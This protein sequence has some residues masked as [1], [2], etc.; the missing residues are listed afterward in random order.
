MNKVI[1][2]FLFLLCALPL[3]AQTHQHGV[4]T[5]GDGQFNPFVTADARG[6]F[7]L[8]YIER[9]NNA[10]NV[11]L[12]HA[13]DGVNFSAPVRVNDQVGDATVRNENPPKVI[14]GPQGDVYVCWA[15]ER[16]KWKG[17]IRFARST[18]GG[19]TFAPALTINSDGT[20]EPAGHAFQSLAVDKQGRIYIAWIDERNKQKE[21]RGAEIWLTISTDR[22]KTF[23]ADRRILTDVCECCRTNLQTDASGNLYLSY[24]TV[25]RDGPMFRD[26]IVARSSD[27]GKTFVPTVVSLD[28]W[29][30]NG[31][32]VAGPSL[33]VSAN[34][35]I[36]VAWFMGGIEK[37]GLYYAMSHDSGT[38]FTTRQW[39][40]A[41]KRMGKHVHSALT[42]NGQFWLAW[43]D[44][45]EQPFS[46]WGV[47][48]RP[49]SM[50]LPRGEQQGLT[51]PV[52]ATNDQQV[53]IA[54]MRP[55]S[56]DLFVQ[57]IPLTER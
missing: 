43:D 44:M 35:Q 37:P 53:V 14:V 9:S 10:S 26:V 11:M 31:C 55:A 29:E 56:A 18:D 16:G 21:D 32:P 40:P 39:L 8:A 24:R 6:G 51:Y 4:V 17:N 49:S 28:K 23:S 1:V 3:F 20:K 48:K 7:Y 46:S 30:I 25:P 47:I 45:A 15:N 42:K 36:T 57:T 34:G 33:S 19:R 38:T 27:G 52:I 22:G 2:L 5:I 41:Q 12:R 54:A 50:L 13:P